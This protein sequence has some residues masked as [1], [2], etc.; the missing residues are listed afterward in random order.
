MLG[1]RC[2]SVSAATLRIPR[3]SISPSRAAPSMPGPSRRLM[4][5]LPVQ[6]VP[7]SIGVPPLIQHRRPQ[8]RVALIQAGYS[9]F[10]ET[11]TRR[12]TQARQPLSIPH[13]Q[14]ASLDRGL[15]VGLSVSLGQTQER[16]LARFGTHTT[17]ELLPVSPARINPPATTS[18]ESQESCGKRRC[19]SPTTPDW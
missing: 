12:A 19:E 14:E 8:S 5:L 4:V 13:S 15:S 6:L 1:R 10:S 2:W 18:G 3:L 16:M 17:P 7:T 9:A 11:R